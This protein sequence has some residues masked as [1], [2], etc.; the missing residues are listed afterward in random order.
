M[1]P[2]AA[3]PSNER[4]AC[5]SYGYWTDQYTTE[6]YDSHNASSPLY[7]DTSVY[8]TVDRQWMWLLCNEPLFYWEEY[9][10][11]L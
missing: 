2:S 8:N 1:S 4:A 3:K 9:A 6:C 7:T 10:F 5:A 11:P